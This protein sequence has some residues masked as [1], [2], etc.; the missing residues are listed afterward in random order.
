VT[1]EKARV[2]I[3][4]RISHQFERLSAY[5]PVANTIIPSTKF[6]ER[7]F[8]VRKLW[9]RDDVVDSFAGVEPFSSSPR[10]TLGDC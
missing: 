10:S 2:P 9:V 3:F 1:K 8:G 4:S 7:S 6:A 5:I